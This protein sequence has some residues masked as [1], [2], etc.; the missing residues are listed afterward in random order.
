MES[1]LYVFRSMLTF[2]SS[3]LEYLIWEAQWLSMLSVATS[4]WLLPDVSTSK[5]LKWITLPKVRIHYF[6]YRID[7]NSYIIYGTS[8]TEYLV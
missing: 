5:A 4:V 7:H 3:N 2:S 8:Y 6:L 1:I